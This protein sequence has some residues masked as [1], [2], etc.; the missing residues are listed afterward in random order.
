MIRVI[1]INEN[2]ASMD[3]QKKKHFKAFGVNHNDSQSNKTGHSGQL[4]PLRGGTP[5]I[6][7]LI[8]SQSHM[9]SYL[10]RKHKILWNDEPGQLTFECSIL[11]MDLVVMACRVSL[12]E[13]RGDHNKRLNRLTLCTNTPREALSQSCMHHLLSQFMSSLYEWYN[14]MHRIYCWC[15]TRQDSYWWLQKNALE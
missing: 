6:I 10:D 7:F 3:L 12:E 1:V 11:F 8:N 5:V 13:F 4:L 15:F 2:Y 14:F 9:P